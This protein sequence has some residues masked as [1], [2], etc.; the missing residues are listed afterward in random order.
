VSICVIIAAI[1]IKKANLDMISESGK[2]YWHSC[3]SSLWLW[4]HSC[5]V[6][7]VSAW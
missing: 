7:I 1:A 5:N 4:W 6:C 3:V 2:V